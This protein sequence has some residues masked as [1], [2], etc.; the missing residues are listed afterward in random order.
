MPKPLI[1]PL[2]L[3]DDDR[4][5]RNRRRR[6]EE[7]PPLSR[8]VYIMLGILLG[9]LGVHNFYAGHTKTAA[10]QLALG[11]SIPLAYAVG[12]AFVASKQHELASAAGLLMMLSAGIL[13]LTI[14][15]DIVNTKTDAR[16]RWMR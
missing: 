3:P 13:L 2:D 4:P 1:E 8:T 14:L 7:E 15:G 16:G 11:L 12:L 10:I 5:K 9:W 6:E